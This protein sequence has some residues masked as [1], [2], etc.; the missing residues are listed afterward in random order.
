MF[1]SLAGFSQQKDTK[2]LASEFD[3]LLSE[4]FGSN[5]PGATALVSKNGVI[6][7]RKSFGLADMEWNIPMQPDH[8]FRIGS[9]TKQFTAV[10]VLQLMELGK[11]SSGDEITKFIPDY[12]V[13]ENKITIEHLLTHTS[14][15]QDYTS[16]KDYEGRM[17]LDLKPEEMIAH[18]KDQ[19]LRFKPGTRYNYSNSGYFLLGYIIEKITGK[20][21]ADYLEEFFFKPLGME[22]SLYASDITIVKN[23]AGGYSKD[24][25]GYKNSQPISMTQPYA[26]G[27]ILSTVSD[28]F[29]WHV[30]LYSNKLIK[31]ES[32]EKAITRYRLSDGKQTEYGYGLR[33]GYV[34]ESPSIWHAGG[35][36]GFMTM[37]VYL[38]EEDVFVAVFSNCDCNSPQVLASRLAA[39]ATGK[40]LAYKTI[41]VQAAILKDYTGVYEN[42]KGQQ[43]IITA[44]SGQLFTQIGRGEKSELKPY[45]ADRFFINPVVTLEFSRNNKGTVEKLTAR[46]LGGI[47][48]WTK[49]DK[50]FP[51]ADGVKV[52]E[53]LL[54]AYVGTYQVS[55]E[56]VF[57]I[58]KEGEKIFLQAAGQ[59]KLEMFA[60]SDTKFFL[61]VNDAQ[62][63]FIKDESN[64]ISKALLQQ[65]GR[66]A[67][68]KK[69]R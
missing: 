47:E 38:P 15:I 8:V 6:I 68:A 9:L 67:E 31:K 33:L 39:L 54:N 56:F 50:P 16:M 69:I 51:T 30:A 45:E 64:K 49:T 11:L 57:E 23:R 35:I 10:A 41:P 55:P 27:S 17:T 46:N 25:K 19:P 12:P 4:Q 61:K 66:S 26:A 7:Y 65:E 28:L 59:E 24:Q 37:Q 21:Y 58:T 5:A 34:Y 40:P 42:G 22:H 48:V 1:L 20:T 52:S 36:N 62:F 43:Q 32:L 13:G 2:Q 53:K 29:K 3:K 14:G 63:E 44:T 60:E 18:F